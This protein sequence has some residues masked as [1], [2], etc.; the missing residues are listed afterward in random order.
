MCWS[1]Q[2]TIV[3]QERK[4]KSWWT[5][6][7]A[8]FDIETWSTSSTHFILTANKNNVGIQTSTIDLLILIYFLL[9]PIFS[10]KKIFEFHNETMNYVFHEWLLK[11]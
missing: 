8:D 4:A 2:G 6:C 7:I 11:N 9:K 5:I 3:L 10:K 1:Y